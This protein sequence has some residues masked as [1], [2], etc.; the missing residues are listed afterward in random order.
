MLKKK[1]LIAL[2]LVVAVI[3][4]SVPALWAQEA[5]KININTATAE[6]IAK[7]KGIGPKYAER[8]IQYREENG[9]FQ[10]PEDLI[11][12]KGLG[13]KVVEKNKDIIV[14]EVSE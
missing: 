2:T 7:L 14:C 13:P 10:T 3:F 4:L 5:E 6:E 8:I 1:K 9:P 11:K 12:V